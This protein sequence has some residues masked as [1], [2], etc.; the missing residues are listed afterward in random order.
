MPR[1]ELWLRDPEAI[2]VFSD[3]ARLRLLQLLQEPQ[4]VR[5]LARILE[6]PA[7]KLHYHINRMLQHGLIQVAALQEEGSR[8]EKTYQVAARHFRLAN[9]L[10]S[11]APPDEATA[12]LFSEMIEDSRDSLLRSLARSTADERPVFTRKRLRLNV[13]GEQL[14][15]SELLQLITRLNAEEYQSGES[16]ARSFEFTL[17]YNPV[18]EEPDA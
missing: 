15:R 4:S 10:A 17:I 6:M 12:K 9:P 16:G 18:Q 11:E 1:E 5:E 13:Q 2:R 8:I 3:P 7:P 14:L